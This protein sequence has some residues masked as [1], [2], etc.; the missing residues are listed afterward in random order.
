ILGMAELLGDTQLT[1]EQATYVKATRTSGE[2]LL[3]LIEEVL[4]FSKIEAGKLELAPAPLSL[5]SLIEDVVELM[6]PRAH[7]KGLEIAADVDERLRERV[8]GDVTRLRQVLLNLTGNAI[9]FTETG[10]V[11]VI[12]EAGMQTGEIAFAVRDTGIGIAADQLARIF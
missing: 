11:S 10:G 9:K 2:A 1:P 12:V 3:S 6:G 5:S 4:D 8:A 7:A